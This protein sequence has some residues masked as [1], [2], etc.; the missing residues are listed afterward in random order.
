MCFLHILG[1]VP[2]SKGI[3][4]DFKRSQHKA[5]P[6][7]RIFVL[8]SKGITKGWLSAGWRPF[9]FLFLPTISGRGIYFLQL[10]DCKMG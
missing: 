3:Q 7:V 2:F 9:S 8:F 5:P 6:P 10:W 4:A 1:D